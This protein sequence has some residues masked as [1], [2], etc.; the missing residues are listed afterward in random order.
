MIRD[1]AQCYEV[2]SYDAQAILAVVTSTFAG[3]VATD[4]LLSFI[5]VLGWAAKSG[6]ASAT[7]FVAGAVIADHFEDL[8]NLPS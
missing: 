1:I 7:T 3:Q 8:S 5:P 4:V 2:H 6:T